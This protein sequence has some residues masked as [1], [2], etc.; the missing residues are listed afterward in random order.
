MDKVA[1]ASI[2]G[3]VQSSLTNFKYLR[4]VW[5]Q[6]AEEERLL[7]IS[8]TG[9]QDNFIMS[10]RADKE[11]TEAEWDHSPFFPCS[12]LDQVLKT[13][14]EI[15]ST[16]NDVWAE[17]LKINS[18]KQLTLIKP[19]G[20]VSQLANCSSGIHPRLFKYYI[21][22]VAQDIKDPI[23]DLMIEQGVPYSLS[24]EKYYF[25]FP[26]ESPDGAVL[27]KDMC[28]LSQ[29]ELWKK[30]RDHWCDGN[31]SQTIYYTDDTFLKIQEWVWCN[32]DS[33]GGLSFFPVNDHVY[34]NAP[35]K[36]IS[37]EEYDKLISEFPSTIDW[38]KLSEFE[39][40]DC[41]ADKQEFACAGGAC[42]F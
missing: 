14:A 27:Q 6:N 32:W 5:K 24:G 41:T 9:V 36:E 1:L 40:E 15:S 17:R 28:A 22:T 34:D 39:K 18:S 20:T 23:S 31:P 7:G 42:N 2:I 29:L 13:L 25:R 21:R 35:Y 4:K 33:V 12:S 30:Y 38:S 19:S 37:K 26:I 10:G 11:Y 3:T 16:M 8:L